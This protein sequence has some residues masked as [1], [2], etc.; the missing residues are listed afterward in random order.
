MGGKSFSQ[1]HNGN[2]TGVSS[3]VA[4]VPSSIFLNEMDDRAASAQQKNGL[5]DVLNMNYPMILCSF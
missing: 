1:N 3:G 4:P 5:H 2:H